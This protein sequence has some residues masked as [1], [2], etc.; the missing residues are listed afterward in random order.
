MKR[1]CIRVRI[2]R[3]LPTGNGNCRQPERR[4]LCVEKRVRRRLV[5]WP[6][7][8][9]ET[10]AKFYFGMALYPARS[11]HGG[12]FPQSKM[13]SDILKTRVYGPSA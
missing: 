2:A 6:T 12:Q 5:P 10:T 8:D 7:H 3:G 13:G 4:H 11:H 9:H 1:H